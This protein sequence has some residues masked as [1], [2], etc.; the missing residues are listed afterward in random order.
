MLDCDN[1]FRLIQYLIKHPQ[2]PYTFDF[3]RMQLQEKSKDIRVIRYYTVPE[4]EKFFKNNKLKI[5]SVYGNYTKDSLNINSK[6]IILIGRKIK[7]SP[8]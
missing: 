8:K 4:L 5:T 2:A 3:V 7:N 1:V 6:R